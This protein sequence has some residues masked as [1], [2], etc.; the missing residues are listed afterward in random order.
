MKNHTKMFGFMKFPV[1]TLV[2]PKHLRLTSYWLCIM[3]FTRNFYKNARI[4]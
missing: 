2:D 1:K 3:S 4:N